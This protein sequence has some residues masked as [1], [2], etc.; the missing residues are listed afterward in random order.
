[1]QQEISK[2][3]EEFVRLEAKMENR[4][5]E[6]KEEF[7]ADLQALLGQYFGPPPATHTDKGKG[8]LGAPPGFPS[9]EKEAPQVPIGT[10]LPDSGSVHMQNQPQLG[11]IFGKSSRL[12]CPKF[13]G[14]DFRGW[15]T[16]LEQYFEAEATP[17]S[18]KVRIMML[19]LEGRALEWHHFYSQRNGGLQKLS[20]PAYLKS[21]QDRF[22][23]GQFG[24]PMKELV[25]LRQQGTVEQYQDM[26]VGILNQL[27]LPENYALS[28]F[29]SNL[30]TEISHYLE[31][32]EPSTLMEAFQLARKI[33]VLLSCSGRKLTLPASTSPRSLPSPSVV[34]GYSSTPTRSVVGSQSAS[35]API[36]KSGPRS[37]SPALMVKRKQK[38][39]CFWCRAKYQAGHKCVRSQLY[40]VLLDPLSDS[41]AEEFQECSDKLDENV[42][43]EEASKS[44]VISL[45]ALTGLQ[46]HNTMRVAARVGSTRAII[47]IDSGSTHN[48]ID[49]RL[50]SKL[51]L[52]VI[53]QEQL[54]VA[55]ANGSY[56]FTRGLCRG[57]S[58]EVQGYHFETDLMVLPLK[59]CDIVLGV[60]WLLALGDIIWNFGSLT[61]Q[62]VVNGQPCVIQ[63][64]VPGSL[65]VVMSSPEQVT[66]LALV[67]N[68]SEE[69]LQRLLANFDDIFQVPKGLPPYRLHDH[70]IPLKNDGV[71]IKMRL[72]RYPAIQKNEIEKLIR[73]CNTPN[74]YPL[75]KQVYRV[76]ILQAGKIRDSNSSFASP[77]VMV[78]K[79][80]GSWRL[81]V[82][83]RQLNQ[84]TIK[85]KFPIPIIEELLDE[86]G[87][88][89]VFSKLDLRSGYH[90]IRTWEPDALMNS[91]FKPLLRKFV[92]VFFDDILVYSKSWP[93]HLE[94]LHEVL[95][96]L[97]TQQ[98]FA[99]KTKCCFGTSQIE[100]LGHVLH[101]GMV[102]MDKSK[103]ACISSWPVP[104]SVK[105]L[106]SFLGLSG[107]YRRFIK[108]YGV[109][110]KPLT[111][112]LKKNRW[113]WS[114]QASRAFLALKEALC[115]APVLVLPNF[116]LEFT[117][118]TDA[119]GTGVGAVLQQQGRPVAFF[120]KALG[121][122]HQALSIYKK[123]MLAVLL[124]VRKWHT[125]LV[126]RHFKIRTDHQSLRF[127]SDQVAITPLQQRWVAKMLGCNFEVSYRKGINNKVADALSCQPQLEQC[128]CFQVSISSAISGLLEQV[129]QL[130]T[131]D[132]KRKGKIVVG[133]A[134]QLRQ[135]L[136]HY[137]HASTMGGHSGVQATKRRVASLLYWKGLTT[138]VKKW[139]R[140]C[141]ICQ[142]YKGETVASPG[143]LQPLPI[144]ERAWSVISLDFI[145]GLPYSNKKNSILVV[146]DHLTK[147]GHFLAL[148]HPF[149][150]KDVA[151]EFLN[152]VY[153]LHGMPDAIISDRDRIFISNFWQE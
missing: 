87:E 28:I 152:H 131:T 52:P 98:L 90:Q 71:I 144:L 75:P 14:S 55:V 130:Y 42:S 27:H 22:G 112:L 21:L 80:D 69:K 120:S 30:K 36:T 64:I 114:D 135:E 95:L 97:R 4:F 46:G 82:D 10:T 16:K 58:W 51:S 109:M 150:A 11:E 103:I 40:Q 140:E 24:N 1:M 67:V 142:K 45:H 39:L 116:Q 111:E 151:Q 6:F 93:E 54:R 138:D 66:L 49:A 25:T 31:L 89:R 35:N 81:C 126:G 88:A 108:D 29:I 34:S 79:K 26:F 70:K 94:H 105:E 125:Y 5:Q 118:N 68:G 50:V 107:Y 9:K 139:I 102:F 59:G 74:P 129:Q 134:L 121:I 53:R 20:W 56:M 3:Q 104:S 43:D 15:W 99:K 117:V 7:R 19:N 60:Q 62:F 153:K 8:V 132:D 136:F 127:L 91:I 73:E 83:Y 41:E 100:Y 47:L 57:V 44:P 101:D 110:A 32:F 96:I 86:L 148:S 17:E 146:V 113:S 33:E 106:R 122:R 37:I 128:Q 18:S 92:L 115:A 143:L 72:Y 85:D 149:T 119:S 78:K 123:E 141:V 124:A 133:K 147:Y 137:F 23:F 76:E 65:A 61:M 84:H 63:C 38:G 145:E 12:E 13:D 48:F 2:L 77:I